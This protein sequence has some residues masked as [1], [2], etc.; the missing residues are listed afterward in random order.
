MHATTLS[1]SVSLV[2]QAASTTALSEAQADGQEKEHAAGE[3]KLERVWLSD[4][5]RLRSCCFREVKVKL[6][7]VST[8][9]SLS[10]VVLLLRS[11][12]LLCLLGLAPAAAPLHGHKPLFRLWDCPHPHRQ[13]HCDGGRTFS[14]DFNV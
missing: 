7:S 11:P 9:L 14:N 5:V 1:I 10:R 12:R 4:S 3:G 8:S 2:L 13:H 6:T